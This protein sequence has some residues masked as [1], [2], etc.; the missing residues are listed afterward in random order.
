MQKSAKRSGRIIF[1]IAAVG[2]CLIIAALVLS[3][4]KPSVSQEP[5][6]RKIVAHSSAGLVEEAREE[7]KTDTETSEASNAAV[8]V[9]SAAPNRPERGLA[10]P[11][12]PKM[13][14]GIPLKGAELRAEAVPSLSEIEVKPED[15]SVG[16]PPIRGK[17]YVIHNDPVFEP[18]VDPEQKTVATSTPYVV[19]PGD[20][21]GRIAQRFS[22]SV[23]DIRKANNIKGDHIIVGQKLMIP[24][25]GDGSVMAKLAE[26]EDVQDSA[27]TPKR[28][29]WW[30][31][32]KLNTTS[33]P[34]LMQAKGFKAPS[35]FM[36]LVIEISFDPTRTVIIRE[37]AFDYNGSSRK[38]DGWNAASTVKLFAA[39]A[40][41]KRLDEL[42]FTSRAKVTF[43]S[44]KPYTTTV[45]ELVQNAIIQSDN[46]AYNRVVQLAGF[47]YMHTKVLNSNYG[48]ANTALTRGYQLGDWERLG[49]SPSLRVAPAITL[50]EG[51]KT[52][53]IPASNSKLNVN[54]SAAA[55]TTIQDLAESTRRLMLQEQLPASESYNLKH[56]D[57]IMLR[58]A[59]RA[60]RTRGTEMVDIFAAVFKDERVKFYSKPGFSED[61][62]TDNVYIFDPRHNQ[63]WIVTMSG[64]PGRKSLNSAAKAIATLIHK[65]ELR[66]IN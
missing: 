35:H 17:Y 3:L 38:K 16:T 12:P 14:E 49:E 25:C 36:A 50:K 55:C 24:N 7:L 33:L 23:D 28:G 31:A 21:L 63:A 34:K 29:K 22:C 56:S 43:H 47:E 62:F 20:I 42:G 18:G 26:D 59:M 37:R 15:N 8:V 60:E 66:K 32:T 4:R 9:R 1:L 30:K 52:H 11:A 27:P 40:A 46:I 53:Q 48:I 19:A 13:I 5:V 54:C 39:I 64:Y 58:R 2:L 57:L 51:A 6:S 65:G 10:N 45:S 44:K 61:W 41:L